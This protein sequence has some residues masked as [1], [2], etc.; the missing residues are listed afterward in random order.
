MQAPRLR[1]RPA[2]GVELDAAEGG[3]P[4]QLAVGQDEAELALVVAALPRCLAQPV[5]EGRPVVGMDP[6][7]ARCSTLSGSSGAKPNSSRHFLL[8]E[9]A[10]ADDVARPGA[11]V[12][13]VGGQ[14]G[15][16]LALAQLDDQLL[17]AQQ[18]GAERVAHD[19]RRRRGRTG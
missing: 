3:D 10:A 18:V 11:E 15:L 17:G 14:V 9:H 12:G 1:K 6:L 13:R 8:A 19:E 7:A 4:A 16:V 2:L 5:A